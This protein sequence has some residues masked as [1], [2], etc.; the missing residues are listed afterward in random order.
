MAD[1]DD[2]VVI[3]ALADRL[4][5]EKIAT[6]L[7]EM[8]AKASALYDETTRE[9]QDILREHDPI[10]ILARLG[11]RFFAA[12]ANPSP[13]QQW[14]AAQQH[15]LELLQAHALVNQRPT[16]PKPGRVADVVERVVELLDKN[17][18]AFRFRDTKAPPP[19][20][21]EKAKRRLLLQD[22]M[23]G[24]TQAVRGEFHPHQ[25]D[26]YLRLVLQRIDAAFAEQ[27][28]VTATALFDTLQN[29]L[30]LVEDRLNNY[31]R[32][33]YRVFRCH[34]PNKAIKAY[35]AA[36]PQDTSRREEIL[37]E[38]GSIVR[39]EHTRHYLVEQAEAFLPAVYT[40][41]PSDIATAVPA[42][43]GRCGREPG[44]PRVVARLRRIERPTVRAFL[45]GESCLGPSIHSAARRQHLLAKSRQH[46]LVC[47]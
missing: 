8:G 16:A 30:R 24:I 20:T 19:G 15:H 31:R 6:A 36:F 3:P 42:R 35:F 17:A 41:T 21:E 18:E 11:W 26:R 1:H 22:Q 25:L 45:S 34:K 37:T 38:V 14:P 40:L 33:A 5:P 23:R 32:L 9:L 13:D 7:N 4:S 29:L 39:P 46:P 27:H 47:L 10:A 12:Q 44:N 43:R 28:G 2:F